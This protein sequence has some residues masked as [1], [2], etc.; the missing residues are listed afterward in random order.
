MKKKILFR[1][2]AAELSED[3]AAAEFFS[4]L[5]PEQREQVLD[6]VYRSYDEQESVARSAT[7]LQ[8]L[9]QGRIDFI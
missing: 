8:R 7:A 1:A 9:R 3:L 5:S 2:F 4:K 6:Y